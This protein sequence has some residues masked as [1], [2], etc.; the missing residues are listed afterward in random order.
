MTHSRKGDV[1]VRLFCN[2]MYLHGADCETCAADG[3]TWFKGEY[4][5]ITAEAAARL[6]AEHVCRR[7]GEHAAA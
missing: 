2:C 7:E 1:T 4:E 3:V 6:V 5:V